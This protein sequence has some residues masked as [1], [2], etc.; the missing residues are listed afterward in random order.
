MAIDAKPTAAVAGKA[1]GG[2]TP[3]VPYCGSEEGVGVPEG[4]GD[5]V[6]VDVGVKV[7]VGVGVGEGLFRV[8]LSE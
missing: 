1:S 8:M 7:E 4:E 2:I 5:C 3:G 6:G